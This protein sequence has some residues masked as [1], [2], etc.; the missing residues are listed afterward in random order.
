[1]YTAWETGCKFA[2]LSTNPDD[3]NKVTP[4]TLRH[5]CVTWMLDAG[6]TPWQVGQY[7]GMSAETVERVYGHSNDKMKRET[8]NTPVK[9][10]IRNGSEMSHSRPTDRRESA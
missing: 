4:H 1:V 3:P 10:P 8:A 5:T 9:K 7:V 6:K 2:G